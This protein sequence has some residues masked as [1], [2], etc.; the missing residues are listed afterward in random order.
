MSLVPASVLANP[1]ADARDIVASLSTLSKLVARSDTDMAP[2]VANFAALLDNTTTAQAKTV[3]S[4]AAVLFSDDFVNETQTFIRGFNAVSFYLLSAK[5]ILHPADLLRVCAGA[6]ISR[7]DDEV[8]GDQP[9][10]PVDRG[11]RKCEGI[12][13]G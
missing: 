1:L 5:L 11:G 9:I 3:I 12:R 6:A 4:G 13:V 10:G 2:L 7:E 8:V